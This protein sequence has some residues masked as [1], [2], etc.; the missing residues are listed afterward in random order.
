[1]VNLYRTTTRALSRLKNYSLT[2][3]NQEIIDFKLLYVE[4]ESFVY[5]VAQVS[6]DQI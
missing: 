3:I 5:Y 6:T 2:G 1:M 4:L